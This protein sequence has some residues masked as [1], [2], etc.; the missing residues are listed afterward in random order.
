MKCCGGR[1]NR[2][3]RGERN[4]PA[5]A[6]FFEVSRP[7]PAMFDESELWNR[8]R[9]TRRSDLESLV[10]VGCL[11][12]RFRRMGAVAGGKLPTGHPPFEDGDD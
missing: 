4:S 1:R 5:T 2:A 9:A 7:I 11:E 6:S 12:G 10:V 3:N 8:V